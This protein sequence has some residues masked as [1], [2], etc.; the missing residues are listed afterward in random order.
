MLVNFGANIQAGDETSYTALHV[1][2]RRGAI[3]VVK[4]L[5]ERG[6]NHS[7]ATVDG[8]TPMLMAAFAGHVAVVAVILRNTSADINYTD[9]DGRTALHHSAMR[10]HKHVVGLYSPAAPT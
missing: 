4:V 9:V 6:A 1:V 10:G 7:V 2:A 3:K 8:W 5:L